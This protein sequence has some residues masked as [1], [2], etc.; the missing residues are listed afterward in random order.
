MLT[1]IRN[2][3][4]LNSKSMNK[5]DVIIIGGSYSGLS[6][7]MSL[8]RASRRVLII[9]SNKPCNS[10]TPHSHNFLTRDGETPA[11]IKA[12]AKEQVKAYP[13]VQFI[14]DVAVNA[15]KGQDSFRVTTLA[16]KTY[17]ACKLLF[18]TGIEDLMPDIEG[19]AE[20][21]GISVIHCPYCHGYEVKGDKTAILANGDAAMH[22]SS[23]LLQWTTDLTIF[24]NGPA[25]F[26]AEQLNLLNKYNIPIIPGKVSALE[27]NDGQLHEIVMDNSLRYKFG[28]M[29]YRP[30]F[31]QHSD[32]PRLLGCT[33]NDQGYIET[34]DM[35]RTTMAGIFAAGDNSTSLRSIASAVAT[36]MKA[37]AIVNNELASEHFRI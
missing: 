14:T 37:G 16:G 4:N 8:G 12:I 7:A 31:R 3:I 2:I 35:Q 23:L 25:E 21:W 30:P 11:A 32:L 9:D 18:T 36:G 27:Q 10:Q 17:E 22:Y 33:I 20:C 1:L 26:T 13:T 19:F 29:Y 15:G 5:Y 6:A 24:T 28:I 34:D